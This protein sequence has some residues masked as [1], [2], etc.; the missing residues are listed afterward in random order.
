MPRSGKQGLWI[1]VSLTASVI[2]AAAGSAQAISD[3]NLFFR[4]TQAV[5]GQSI[6]FSFSEDQRAASARFDSFEAGGENFLEVTL[7]NTGDDVLLP[8]DILTAVW[9]DL[10]GDPTLNPYEVLLASSSSVVF[11]PA[12]TDGIV[13]GEWAY[14]QRGSELPPPDADQGFSSTGIDLVGAHDLFPGDDL[15]HPP[16]PNG[17]E[18]GLTSEQDDLA[19]GNTPVTGGYP[20]IKHSVVFSLSGLPDGFDVLQDV[21]NVYFSYGTSRTPVPEPLTMV[22]VAGGIVALAGYIRKRRLA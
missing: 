18:Y 2:F 8:V 22:G 16:A 21:S 17:L 19:T 1:S 7:S 4:Y 20:L 9:F 12:P 15:S 13:G 14:W 11:G 5:V 6:T 10:A 3:P